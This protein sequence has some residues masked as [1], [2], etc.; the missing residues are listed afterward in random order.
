MADSPTSWVRA[1]CAGG[2]E[3]VGIREPKEA[4]ERSVEEPPEAGRQSDGA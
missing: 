2:G 4:G 1:A 3:A